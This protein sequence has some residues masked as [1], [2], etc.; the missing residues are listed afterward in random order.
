MREKSATG[1][2]WLTHGYR[3]LQLGPYCAFLQLPS[4]F[5][6]LVFYVADA[7]CQTGNLGKKQQDVFA[8]ASQ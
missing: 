2:K 5:A 6:I 1:Q 7:E 4:S 8:A 3:E